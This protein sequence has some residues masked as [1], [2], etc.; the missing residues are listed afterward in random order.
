MNDE[1]SQNV[2]KS[3]TQIPG[4]AID[5]ISNGG[6][7]N[8]VAAYLASAWAMR[9]IKIRANSIPEAKLCLYD[10]NGKRIKDHPALDIFSSSDWDYSTLWRYT[11]S[12]LL[13]HGAGYWEKERNRAGLVKKISY[14]NPSRVQPQINNSGIYQ[15][16]FNPI[17]GGVVNFNPVDVIH[18]RGE[19]NPVDDIQTY[20][21]MRWAIYSAVGE[22]NAD[23]YINAFWKNGATPTTI[24]L[25]ENPMPPAA[26]ISRIRALWNSLFSGSENQHKTGFLFN[27]QKAQTIGSNMKDLALDVVRVEM[28]R[29]VSTAIGVPELLIAAVAATDIT[30]VE[31]AYKI[32]Y[33]QTIFPQWKMYASALTTQLIP[34]FPDLVLAGAYFEFDTSVV[35]ALNSEEKLVSE[36]Q[37]IEAERIALL[38]E[39]RLLKPETAIVELGYKI[40]DLPE[41]EEPKPVAPVVTGTAVQETEETKSAGND[42][43]KWQKKSLNSLKAG[44]SA[45][46]KFETDSITAV[47]VARIQS[48]LATAQTKEDVLAVFEKKSEPTE[49]EKLINATLE[50][51]YAIRETDTRTE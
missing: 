31:M 8:E 24:I 50:L 11:E 2:I 47:E 4:W 40:S 14:L 10:R 39:K 13:V 21:A 5:Y 36:R 30:P 34:E 9:A 1:K 46:V 16:N 26:E 41:E 35:Q 25:D 20:S 38:V 45:N 15:F 23:K 19:Y 27:G 48:G 37:K 22:L 43:E 18:F 6:S 12:G 29:T 51:S 7:A 49:L 33:N 32:Y 44:K 28:H 17:N 42:L 3:I